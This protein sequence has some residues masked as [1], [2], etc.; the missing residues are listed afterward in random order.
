MQGDRRRSGIRC[1]CRRLEAHELLV[2]HTHG[3]I[4]VVF[5][6]EELPR[7]AGRL[8]VLCGCDVGRQNNQQ[9]RED[10]PRSTVTFNYN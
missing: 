2:D 8:G 9:C 3:V 1:V 7:A 4:A 6:L 5:I 10:S